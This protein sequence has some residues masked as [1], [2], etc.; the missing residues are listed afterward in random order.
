MSERTGRLRRPLVEIIVVALG[1]FGGLA[2]DEW[3]GVRADAAEAADYRVRLRADLQTDSAFLAA[4]LEDME[5]A[6]P[7]LERLAVVTRIG[8]SEAVDEIA[9]DLVSG[10]PWSWGGIPLRR[11]TMDELVSSG[12]LGL[13]P[14]DIRERLGDF[15]TAA[16]VWEDNLLRRRRDAGLAGLASRFIR[17]A[18]S[19]DGGS[20]LP[21]TELERDGLMHDLDLA[22][23]RREARAERNHALVA[24]RYTDGLLEHVERLLSVLAEGT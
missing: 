18:A 12:D 4:Q 8:D 7:A 20:V 19:T 1:V 21:L 15:Y 11:N 17:K 6:V 22:Q 13:L 2:A 16:S 14:H 9:A 5:A 24:Q 23:L 3:R 10:V